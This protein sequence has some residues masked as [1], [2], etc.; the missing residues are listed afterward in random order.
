VRPA[1]FLDRGVGAEEEGHQAVAV[2]IVT[3]SGGLAGRLEAEDA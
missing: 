1:R 2:A 3:R